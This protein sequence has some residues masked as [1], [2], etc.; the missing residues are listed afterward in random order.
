[1]CAN[2]SNRMGHHSRPTCWPSDWRRPIACWSTSVL[3][4]STSHRSPTKAALA[5]SPI[6]TAASAA[7]SAAARP[8][9]ARPQ[10]AC[11]ARSG[12]I[13]KG[14]PWQIELSDEQIS[15]LFATGHDAPSSRPHMTHCRRVCAATCVF[16]GWVTSDYYRSRKARVMLSSSGLAM[17]WRKVRSEDLMK[18]SA[19]I[20]GVGLKFG[21]VAASAASKRTLTT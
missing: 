5:T 9:F 18:T 10:D 1:M 20:P 8:I 17:Y 11:G 3:A 19:G 4:I 14:Q 15:Q 2:C 6:S 7:S 13:V 12:T 16:Q 21:R